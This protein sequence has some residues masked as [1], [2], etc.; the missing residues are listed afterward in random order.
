MQGHVPFRNSKLTFLLQDCLSGQS[1][2]LMFCN[3]SPDDLDRG[4]SLCSLKFAERVRACELGPA[5]KAGPSAME[6][7]KMKTAVRRVNT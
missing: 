4:E 5:A 7:N 3:V 2:S 6:L 1:K